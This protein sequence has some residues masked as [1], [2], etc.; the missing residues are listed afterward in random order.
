MLSV[1]LHAVF[2]WLQARKWCFNLEYLIKSY[3]SSVEI[4]P[5]IFFSEKN[6]LHLQKIKKNVISFT[7][8]IS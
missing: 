3:K 6:C 5:G 1:V 2:I 4:L 7:L 8:L